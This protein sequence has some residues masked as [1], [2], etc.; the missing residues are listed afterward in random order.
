VYGL[1][2]KRVAVFA[3]G[4]GSNFQA[5]LDAQQ[6][7]NYEIVLLICDKEEAMVMKRAKE[8][9]VD[10]HLFSV[11]NYSGKE[12][13]EVAILKVLQQYC[14]DI[15]ALAGYMRIVGTTI[16]QEFEGSIVNIHPSL[17][18]AFPGK[19]AIEQALNHGVC[20]TGVT[21]HYIDEGIDT[22]PIIAQEPVKIVRTDTIETL[23]KKINKVETSLYPSV[24]QTICLGKA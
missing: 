12:A 5:L 24:L 4:N 2:K 17:L 1:C 23:Q 7:N 18:P 22:G 3:S 21:I 11:K 19:D 16:L 9:K 8:A 14:V 6:S 15:I 20:I 13:Y 10:T